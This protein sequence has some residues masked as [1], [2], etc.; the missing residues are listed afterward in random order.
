MKAEYRTALAFLGAAALPAAY[1]AVA[2]PLSGVR[3]PS[4]IFGTFLVAYWFSCLLAGLV[5]LPA[6]LL[7]SKFNLVTWWSA[8]G[9]G[10]ISGVVALVAILGAFEGPVALR[11][12]VLGAGAG[13][14]FWLVLRSGP[15]WPL[16]KNDA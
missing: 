3:D 13:L 10:A 14:L 11:Y 4:S 6:F 16:A 12:S 2:S 1:L 15:A 9:C 5:G 8:I 7:L